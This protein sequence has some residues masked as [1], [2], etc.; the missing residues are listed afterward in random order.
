MMRIFLPVRSC[1]N[2]AMMP[3]STSRTLALRR[4]LSERPV[5][6]PPLPPSIFSPSSLPE[7]RPVRPS[8]KTNLPPLFMAS[9]S[10]PIRPAP[11]RQKAPS[12]MKLTSA[13]PTVP[14]SVGCVAIS[15]P[16]ISGE[17]LRWE[18]RKRRT[19]QL[20]LAPRTLVRR[21]SAASGG[22]ARYGSRRWGMRVDMLCPIASVDYFLCF[23]SKG[24]TAPTKDGS[25]DLN[26]DEKRGFEIRTVKM[27]QG[28]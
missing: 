25:S 26:Y 7:N 5:R 2:A 15:D 18:Y 24:G 19:S 4:T 1:P 17:V 22:R 14:P 23:K 10:R 27:L 9:S 20:E 8:T 13:T 16:A 21:M 12:L 6:T 11:S 28:R 3:A